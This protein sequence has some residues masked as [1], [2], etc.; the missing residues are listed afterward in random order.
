[1]QTIYLSLWKVMH[2]KQVFSGWNGIWV[3]A[4]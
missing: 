1:M 3:R 4:P 2:Q